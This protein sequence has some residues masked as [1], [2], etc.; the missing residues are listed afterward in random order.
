MLNCLHAFIHVI[1]IRSSYICIHPLYY[2]G[3]IPVLLKRLKQKDAEWRK[4]RAEL[5]K[6]WREVMVRNYEKSFDHR[7]F[8]FRQQVCILVIIAVYMDIAWVTYW[9]LYILLI[10]YVYEYM[11]TVV[12]LILIIHACIISVNILY[13]TSVSSTTACSWLK[14]NLCTT[15]SCSNNNNNNKLNSSKMRWWNLPLPPLPLLP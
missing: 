13:R 2:I 8:Y 7:S 11:C 12:V 9:L 4:A 3:T 6:G 15:L 5:N 10:V 1:Y 14:S